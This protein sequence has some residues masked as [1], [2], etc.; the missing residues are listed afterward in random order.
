M[1]QGFIRAKVLEI[2]F[3]DKEVAVGEGDSR[4]TYYIHGGSA[5]ESYNDR[6]EVESMLGQV[7]IQRYRESS[8]VYIMERVGSGVNS[9]QA[10]NKARVFSDVVVHLLVGTVIQDVS[11]EWG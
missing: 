8:G 1:V 7:I 4:G 5:V 6:V 10:W 11:C 2:S 3:R 9:R